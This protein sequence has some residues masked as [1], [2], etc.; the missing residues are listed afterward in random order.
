MCFF[1]K[2]TTSQAYYMQVIITTCCNLWFTSAFEHDPLFTGERTERC[3]FIYSRNIYLL[4]TRCQVLGQV[5]KGTATFLRPSC[6]SRVPHMPH[7]SPSLSPGDLKGHRA[8]CIQLC[9]HHNN[10][11]IY[12]TGRHLEIELKNENKGNFLAFQWLRLGLPT[13]GV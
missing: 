12:G 9:N 10:T 6:H 4:S 8:R 13:Q 11:I 1:V 5:T 2:V 3:A 7:S